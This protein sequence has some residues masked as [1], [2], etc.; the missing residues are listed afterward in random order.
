MIGRSHRFA[1]DYKWITS[2]QMSHARSFWDFVMA[3]VPGQYRQQKPC[4]HILSSF[5]FPGS[6]HWRAAVRA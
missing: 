2:R 5:R 3:R 1:S 4:E 6:R